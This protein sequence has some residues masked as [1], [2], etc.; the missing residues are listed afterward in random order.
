MGGVHAL[1][2]WVLDGDWILCNALVEHRAI[3]TKI[4][5]GCAGVGNDRKRGTIGRR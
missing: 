5:G 1:T 4:C 3:Q 2:I